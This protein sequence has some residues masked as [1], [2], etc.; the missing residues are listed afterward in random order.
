MRTALLLSAALA[1]SASAGEIA[2]K[3]TVV[4]KK[5]RSEGVAVADVNKDGKTDILVGDVW[6]EAPDW[7]VHEIRKPGNYGDGSAGYSKSFACWADDL[8]ADGWADLIV[9]GFPGAPCHWYENPQNKEGHWKEHVI[10]HSACNET[11]AY[12]DLFGDGK[13][14]LLMGWQPQGKENEGQMAWFAPGEDPTKPWTMHAVSAPSDPTVYE[15]RP[16]ALKALAADKVPDAVTAK[17]DPLKGKAFL[18]SKD[19]LAEAGK[20]LT[21]EEIKAFG[22][23]LT[24]HTAVA[25][26]VIPGTH[27]FAHGL[28]AGDV[29]GDGRLDVIVPQGWWE[30]PAEGRAATA[31]WTWHAAK[32]GDACADMFAFD[33]DADGTPDVISSAA[34]RTGVWWHKQAKS[35]A[36]SDFKTNLITKEF[37]QTHAMHFV[38]VNG[39]GKKDLVTGKRWW[40]HGP[41]GDDNPNA[42]PVLY[43][44]EIKPAAT[45]EFVFH[46]IDDDS[47]IGTQFVVTDINGDGAP[48]IV[49]SNKRGTFLFEQIRK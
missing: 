18:S 38:D 12:L 23:K 13:R 35:A 25:G 41:K 48:D 37:S 46:Q 20:L 49:I 6:F 10:W 22:G 34:H 42:S 5:F 9:I 11:P 1:A 45:P 29:N 4:E 17:L 7:K 40:A 15:L 30:Q 47:G 32:L 8:N 21:P 16:Q 31:P 33:V 2:F 27:R 28:G 39:D 24:K 43:W 19:L 14:V 44:I 26:K 36:G 3:K